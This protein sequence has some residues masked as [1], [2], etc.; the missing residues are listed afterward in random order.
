PSSRTRARGAVTGGLPPDSWGRTGAVGERRGDVPDLPAALQVRARL[1]DSPGAHDPPALRDP[2][3]PGPRALPRGRR[4][5]QAGGTARSARRGLATRRLRRNRGGAPAAREGDDRA[6][7]LPRAVPVRR[8][9]A[10]VVRA[11]VLVQAG[12]A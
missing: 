1:S 7:P 4:N 10:R 5:A 6:D 2:R 12:P 8:G 11:P 9:R 3:P